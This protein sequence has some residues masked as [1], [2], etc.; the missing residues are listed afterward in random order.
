MVRLVQQEIESQAT[1]WYHSNEFQTSTDTLDEDYVDNQLMPASNSSID[2]SV[3]S[4]LVTDLNICRRNFRAYPKGHPLVE[5]SL[6]KTIQTYNRLFVHAHTLTIGVSRDRLLIGDNDSDSKNNLLKDFASA[7]YER[8]IGV[9]ILKPGLAR[10]E[11]LNFNI[12]LNTKREEILKHGGIAEIWNKSGITSIDIKPIDYDLFSATE[13]ETISAVDGVPAKNLWT[14]FIKELVKDAHVSALSALINQNNSTMDETDPVVLATMF[15]KHLAAAGY[16]TEADFSGIMHVFEDQATPGQPQVETSRANVPYEKL[17]LFINNLDP[18]LRNRI[19]D[20]SL[21]ISTIS[22][23][24]LG[25]ELLPR[26]SDETVIGIS[27]DIQQNSGNI[28]PIIASL[29][30]QMAKHAIDRK[31]QAIIKQ[32]EDEKLKDRISILLRELDAENQL[33][34][35]YQGIMD[36]VV[37]TRNTR[38]I[39]DEVIADLLSSLDGH[40]FE[41]Q[42]SNIIMQL[43]SE[44][45]GDSRQTSHLGDNL[46][47]IFQ[48]LLQTGDYDQLIKLIEQ[49][50]QPHAS[51]QASAVIK[52]CASSREFM[53]E[54]VV[55]LTNWGK[56]KYEI[57]TRLIRLIGPSFIEVLLDRLAIEENL[58]LRRFIM[59]RL[60][61]FGTT[62]REA[63]LK[64]LDDQRWYVLRNLI[65]MLRSMD[66]SSVVDNIRPLTRHSNLRVRSEAI[67]VCLQFRDSTVERQLIYDMNSQDQN[68]QLSAIDL[69]KQSRSED[70][71]RK[72][73]SYL[74][75]PGLG[76][77]D[78]ELKSAAIVAL[79]ELGRPEAIPEL[80]R[81]ISARS[82]LYGRQLSRLKLEAVMSLARYPADK[83]VPLLLDLSK[84]SGEIAVAAT[85]ILQQFRNNLK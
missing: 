24:T 11:L 32:Q 23:H 22:G 36:R 20:N 34:Q 13:V 12:I 67:R 35:S 48:Y 16:G 39:E 2:A 53:D 66:D 56:P 52:E 15:N 79:S 43:M 30:Q 55:G 61:E 31:H 72:L 64:R 40:T 28:S 25:E 47:E 59:D 63:I 54:I 73:L 46:L 21:D 3:F 41:Q 58:S 74:A 1:F 5:T 60:L 37:T 68:T 4:D 76:D 33:P 65:I 50:G 29:V 75:I 10:H 83:V 85:T 80:S 19:L 82:L 70:V 42:L 49:A 26:L 84:S 44:S 8:G 78:C 27:E 71:F 57:I 17:A 9:I 6:D 69:A 7:L 62:A 51:L 18:E 81:L 14:A 45:G 77:T 38:R